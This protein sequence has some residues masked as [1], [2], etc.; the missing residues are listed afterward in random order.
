MSLM[1]RLTTA[2]SGRKIGTDRF[3]NTYHESRKDFLG[4]GRKRRW[5]LYAGAPEATKVPPEWHAWLHHTANAPLP[6]AKAHPWMVEHRPNPT[7]TALAWH[8]AGHDYSGGRRQV[9]T[10]DYEAWTPG[11]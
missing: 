3:G 10:G 4:Y 2:L 6:E 11:S 1:M 5:V 7:G 9:T 8:P